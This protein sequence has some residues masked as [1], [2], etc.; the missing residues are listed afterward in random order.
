MFRWIA[1]TVFLASLGIS[2][3]YRRR[4]QRAGASVSRRE[5]PTGLILGRAIV[6][7]PLFGGVL[8]YLVHPPW[9]DWATVPVPTSVRW[10]GAVLGFLVV[11][12]IYWVL[13]TLGKNVTATVLTN[14]EHGLVTTGPYRWV[15]HPL[16]T[17]GI[18]LFGSIGLLAASAFILAWTLVAL[19][20]ICAFVIPREESHLVDRFGD[21]Y[22]RY[23]RRTGALVPRLSRSTPP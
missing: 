1:L 5:E 20:G 23:R 21:A 18:A 3:L 14:P 16:Y 10:M 19:V 13:A 12:T 8:A 15:R 4:A 11:P 22:R 6:A 17:A 2:A 7:L 9:M